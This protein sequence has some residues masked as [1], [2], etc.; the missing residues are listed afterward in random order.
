[1]PFSRSS[2]DATTV[3]CGESFSLQRWS[4]GSQAM[5]GMSAQLYT[6]AYTWAHTMCTQT[7]SGPRRLLAHSG[8]VDL[9]YFILI[10][11]VFPSVFLIMWLYSRGESTEYCHFVC[12][13]FCIYLFTFKMLFLVKLYRLSDFSNNKELQSKNQRK[14]FLSSTTHLFATYL[15]TTYFSSFVCVSQII[16]WFPEWAYTKHTSHAGS[17]SVTQGLSWKYPCCHANPHG[18]R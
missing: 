2:W 12:T 9:V 17:L 8:G 18:K 11:F 4:L 7:G 15:E 14:T 13:C 5:A 1:M 16:L 6:H 3:H 10:L